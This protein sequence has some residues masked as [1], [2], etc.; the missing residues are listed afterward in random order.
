MYSWQVMISFIPFDFTPYTQMFTWMRP[1]AAIRRMTWDMRISASWDFHQFWLVFTVQEKLKVLQKSFVDNIQQGD[2]YKIYPSALSDFKY[3]SGAT[4][5]FEDPMWTVKPIEMIFDLTEPWWIW[6]GTHNYF[7]YWLV[8]ND[9]YGPL[10]PL[11]PTNDPISEVNAM[12]EDD[13][14]SI[15]DF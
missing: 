2:S 8:G 4:S 11:E 7:Q 14:A 13:P 3:D 15:L 10:D 6:Y 9:F 1:E 12:A 5:D